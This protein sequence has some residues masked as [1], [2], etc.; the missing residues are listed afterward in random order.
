MEEEARGKEEGGGGEDEKG[1]REEEH[2]EEEAKGT[3]YQ[4]S[5][6]FCNMQ[7]VKGICGISACSYTQISTQLE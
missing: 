1:E 2:E 4:Y 5:I 6:Q 7:L 3:T